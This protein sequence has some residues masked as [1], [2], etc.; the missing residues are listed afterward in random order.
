MLKD[1]GKE[2]LAALGRLTRTARHRASLGKSS[3]AFHLHLRVSVSSALKLSPLL[4]M[5]DLSLICYT[6]PNDAC[7]GEH[8]IEECRGWCILAAKHMLTDMKLCSAVCALS[9]PPARCSD[10]R[11]LSQ[12][13]A[14]LQGFQP[15]QM[16]PRSGTPPPRV[17]G[18]IESVDSRRPCP[19]PSSAV[20][21]AGSIGLLSV[22]SLSCKSA[23]STAS[24]I[25]GSTSPALVDIGNSEEDDAP[26]TKPLMRCAEWRPPPYED[27]W[28]DHPSIADEDWEAWLA[29]FRELQQKQRQSPRTWERAQR[30]NLPTSNAQSGTGPSLASWMDAGGPCHQPTRRRPSK[31]PASCLIGIPDG[32]ATMERVRKAAAKANVQSRSHGGL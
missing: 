26:Q 30:P 16:L 4:K 17:I 27:P 13:V 29:D 2:A 19:L 5:P 23:L 3:I 28:K 24:T 31:L 8:C 7:M 32:E 10:R 25:S 15:V 14:R 9:L 18:V 20:S 11:A 21:K 22:A 1:G 6:R 12:D